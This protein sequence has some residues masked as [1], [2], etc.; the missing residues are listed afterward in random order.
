MGVGLHQLRQEVVQVREQHAQ[1]HL[2]LALCMRLPPM[3]LPVAVAPA[4]RA[5]VFDEPQ[6]LR[7]HLPHAA[8]Q[9][10]QQVHPLARRRQPGARGGGSTHKKGDR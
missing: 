7:H 10:L 9:P 8:V 5:R 2:L 6:H 3:P 4:R 1:P